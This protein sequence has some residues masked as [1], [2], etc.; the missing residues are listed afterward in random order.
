MVVFVIFAVCHL[1]RRRNSEASHICSLSNRVIMRTGYWGVCNGEDRG[2]FHCRSGGVADW[3][4]RIDVLCL[5]EAYL[6]H[7]KPV[8]SQSDL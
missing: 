3:K 6:H 5:P 7:D 1:Y 2:H 4:R 8:L